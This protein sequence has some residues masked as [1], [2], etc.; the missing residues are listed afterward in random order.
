[1]FEV[2]QKCRST[3]ATGAMAHD[4]DF[5]HF[6]LGDGKFER[7]RNAVAAATQFK[8]WNEVCDVA[9]DKHLPRRSIEYGRRVDPAVGAGDH[10]D[11]G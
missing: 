11:V 6:E 5:R 10:H 3:T 2:L 7:G 9:Y 4:E 1:M 8:R